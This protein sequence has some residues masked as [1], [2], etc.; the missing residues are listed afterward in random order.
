M[1]ARSIAGFMAMAMAVFASL[2]VAAQDT[3]HWSDMDCAQSKLV[4]PAGLKC[5]ATQEYSGGSN[6]SSSS[7]GAGGMS[8][9]WAKVGTVDG[10]KLYYYAKEAVAQTSSVFPIVLED[11]LKRV[12]PQAKGASNFSQSAPLAGGDYLKFTSASGDV[13]IGIRKNGSSRSKGF[14]WILLASK[15]VPKGKSISD[16]EI[17][18]F[19]SAA[20]FRD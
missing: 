14:K 20:N 16:E 2:E 19:I 8:R 11:G 6:T 12:S 1:E 10:S 4:T 13:C 18:R 15:C 3:P 17:G 7:S 9:E 5:R